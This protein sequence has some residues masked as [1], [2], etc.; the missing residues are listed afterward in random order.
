VRVYLF[1][2]QATIGCI[3]FANVLFLVIR[4]LLKHKID[5]ESDL[6]PELQLPSIDTLNAL[7][8]LVNIFLNAV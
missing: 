5:P 6:P 1:I 3:V 7:R 8:P 4:S 2:E